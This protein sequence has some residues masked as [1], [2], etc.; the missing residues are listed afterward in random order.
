MEKMTSYTKY[1]KVAGITIQVNSDL[2][3]MED[4]FHPKF[5]IFKVNGPGNDSI[6]INHHFTWDEEL[7]T[8]EFSDQ[9]Y[10]SPPW[11]IYK[12]NNSIIY[13]W[14]EGAPPYKNCN[15]KAIAN[16]THTKI[17]IF[18]HPKLKKIFKKGGQTSLTLFP[19]DQILIGRL[20]AYRQGCIIHSLGVILDGNGFIFVGH[21]DAGKSTMAGILKKGAEILCDDRNIIRKQNNIFQLFGT[22]S[23]GDVPDVSSNSAPLKAV[24]FLEQSK[25]NM[26]EKINDKK[27]IFKTLLACLIRPVG[28][29]DWWENSLDIIT[30][31]SNEIPC[32]NLKFDKSDKVYKLIKE[33]HKDEDENGD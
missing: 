23:H 26:I 19:S 12:D 1:Y 16:H 33:L 3:I 18:T 13:K 8:E 27:R 28:T 20:L 4:T 7:Q 32:W 30:S 9:I 6:V 29:Y 11:A 17:D 2:P 31:I 14:I 25:D 5:K 22:W 10:F 15:R 21:S 24:F